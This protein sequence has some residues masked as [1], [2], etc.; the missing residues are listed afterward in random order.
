M[1]SVTNKMKLQPGEVFEQRF[2]IVNSSFFMKEFT[3]TR[4]KHADNTHEIADGLILLDDIEIAFQIKSRMTGLQYT[5]ES[6][7]KWFVDRLDQA[8][9]QIKDTNQFFLDGGS[10][11]LYNL[12]GDAVDVTLN[13]NGTPH[14]VIVIHCPAHLLSLKLRLLKY[15]F[16]N[17]SNLFVHVFHA[18]DYLEMIKALVTPREID[19]YLS[20]R[21]RKCLSHPSETSAVSEAA[22][23]GQ[24]V[25][26]R[27]SWIPEEG[28][29]A[30]L[31]DINA[32]IKDWSIG[33]ILLGFRDRSPS[34]AGRDYYRILR[35]LALLG[36]N[37]LQKLKER[38]LLSLESSKE[39]KTE[40][41][42]R[43]TTQRRRGFVVFGVP[44][45]LHEHSST[46]LRNFTAAHKYDQKLDVCL[47]VSVWARENEEVAV[48]WCHMEFPWIQDDHWDQ[49]L[50]DDFPFRPVSEREVP[51][52]KTHRR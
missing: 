32:D 37:E 21:G 1:L 41:P 2:G 16:S 39:G 36:R 3:F 12:A 25:S 14:F 45:H 22:L 51:V 29:S 18:E 30:Y 10:H 50:S 43:M 44:E 11:V 9:R 4:C 26:G 5:Q 47:G 49:I 8:M 31:A 13:P 33:G 35:E 20:F 23:L 6:E 40:V 7:D 27:S 52:F 17:S 28:F 19:S 24:F 34:S 15:R 42:Y 38:L 48:G 46:A